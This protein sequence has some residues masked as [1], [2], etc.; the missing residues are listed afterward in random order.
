MRSI[1]VYADRGAAMA[2][3]LETALSLGRANG[4]HVTVVVDT[5]VT[6]YIAMDPMGGAVNLPGHNVL[7]P[8]FGLPATWIDAALQDE[9]QLRG[10]TVVD[11]ATVISTH[12]TEVLK[13]HMPELLS[14]GEV[15][16]LLRELPKDHADLVKEIVP[17]QISTTGIQRVLQLLGPEHQLVA[18]LRLALR[19]NDQL[20]CLVI[21][22]LRG[23]SLSSCCPA[24]YEPGPIPGSA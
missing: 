11:A 8:T 1:L 23:L 5:P 6:R 24:P 12:L 17:N 7:E 21:R 9:A 4:G 20:L 16:K 3:R 10:F 19:S 22:H 15:Q 14:H 2:G 13:S 18:G